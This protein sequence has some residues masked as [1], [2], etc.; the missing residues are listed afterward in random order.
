VGIGAVM[1]WHTKE[2]LPADEGFVMFRFPGR[3]EAHR[4]TADW[5]R[6]AYVDGEWRPCTDEELITVGALTPELYKRLIEEGWQWATSRR[7]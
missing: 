4:T 3:K 7:A 2:Q 5:V 1:T 6:K